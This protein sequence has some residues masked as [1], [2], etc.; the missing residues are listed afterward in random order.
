MSQLINLQDSNQ[1]LALA[2]SL[3]KSE[4][5]PTTFKNPANVLVALQTGYEMGLMPMQSLNSLYIINGKVN[6]YGSTQTFLLK[7]HGWKIATENWTDKSCTVRVHK[8]EEKYEYTTAITDLTATSKAKS[9]APK[10]KLYYHCISRIIRSYL[11]EVL[12]GNHLMTEYDQDLI[13][14][15]T[16]IKKEIIDEKSKETELFK[17]I[18][19]EVDTIEALHDIQDK[20]TTEEEKIAYSAREEEFLNET[21]IDAQKID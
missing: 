4:A 10:E 2:N 5:L 11:P 8:G 13:E 7:K 19:Y 20:V 18:A 3:C 12:G 21:F 6:I 16:S 17:Y 14:S 15:N 9:F 1:L